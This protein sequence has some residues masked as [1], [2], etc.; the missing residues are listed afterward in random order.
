MNNGSKYKGKGRSGPGRYRPEE[1]IEPSMAAGRVPPHDLDAESAVL[2]AVMLDALALDSVLE[3]L[4]PEYFYSDA[5]GKIF[6]AAV[7]LA[8]DHKPVDIV[9]VAGVLRDTNDGSLASIGN[10]TYLAQI[11]DATPAVAHI[12]AHAKVVVEKWR[13]RQLIARC[14]KIAAEG[15]GEVDSI[16][17]FIDQ[18][19]QAI[20]ELAQMDRGKTGVSA[21]GTVLR[22][23]FQD[24]HIA[25]QAGK[26]MTG[27][28]T[29]YAKFD[30][31]TSGQH[32]GDLT[33]VAA[34]PGMGKTAMVLNMA[35]NVA[36]PRE[37]EVEGVRHTEQGDGVMVFSLEMPREQLAARMVCSEGRVDLGKMR[38]AMLQP[39]DWR[40]LTEA[41]SY[42]SALPIWLDDTPAITLL[43]VRAKVR[44][45]QAEYNRAAVA[46]TATSPAVPARKVGLV[47]IDYLQLMKGTGDEG[48]REQE[49]SALS[50]G[51][52]ALAK[53]LRI[54]VIALSQLNRA[55]ETRGKDKRPQ[56]SDLR[57]S[58]AIEQDADMIVF[59]FRPAY[60]DPKNKPGMA[61]LI[62]A[63]Q[64]NGP[65][66]TVYVKYTDSYTRFEDYTPGEAPPMD[67]DA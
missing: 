49:I 59:I 56:L 13:L 24:M 64:R 48:S 14:Q 45:Q 15:Y 42:L 35:V 39:D 60:Y 12:A 37:L 28:P 25:A 4:K 11:A 63:K 22:T 33:I 41:A 50:R 67:D 52:K 5:N 30:E 66:G 17:E 6:A 19:E 44:R 34:R 18:A 1:R 62:I 27:T 2:A 38:N 3:I 47:V 46:A 10:A 61:E 31:K 43:E 40:R 54:P 36:S 29:G 65:T 55:V 51:L 23:V 20:Y 8:L 53:E 16:Q 32:E 21:I 26:R 9:T 57:E 58:G 7:K